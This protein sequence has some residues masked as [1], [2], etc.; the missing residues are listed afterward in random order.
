MKLLLLY[1]KNR[2][3]VFNKKSA[4]GSYVNYLGNLLNQNGFEVYLNGEKLSEIK[5]NE[6]YNSTSFSKFAQIKKIIPSFIKRY[7]RE[8]K[9]LSDLDIFSKEL[10][11]SSVKYDFILEYYNMGS[12]VGLKVSKSQNVPYY[13][14]YDGP[15]LDEYRIFN[16]TNPFFFKE[17]IKR[18]KESFRH[19]KKIVAQSNPMKD[20]VIKNIVNSPDKIYIHQNVDYTKFDVLNT[21]K[22]FNTE[23]L[24]IGFIGS[25]LP[26]HQVELLVNAF[27]FVLKNGVQANLFLIGDGME[28]KNIESYC[29]TLPA[30]IKN[31][32]IFTG[33]VKEKELY[34]LKTKLD[35]GVMPGSNWYGAPLKIFEYGAM[36]MACIAPDT[37]TIKD[38]FS[39]NEVIFFKWKNQDSLNN[40]LLN[41][42][43]NKSK[44]IKNSK[45]LNNKILQKYSEKNTVDFYEKLI[46]IN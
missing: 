45:V 31:K 27:M 23:I 6:G 19:A 46:Q 25:F 20:Y 12:D 7:L 14:F 8:K 2:Q 21:D 22:T 30:T 41:L 5:Y 11:D 39:N 24:N 34:E 13:I 18:E 1:T 32:I 43:N 10:N 29:E 17:V 35:I 42:C 28:K 26:W 37:P 36:K 16:K 9:H 3:E 33:F 40:T 44:M 4:I 38:L 15:I